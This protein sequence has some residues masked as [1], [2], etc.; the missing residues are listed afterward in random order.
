M[1]RLKKINAVLMDQGFYCKLDDLNLQLE[2]TRID[3]NFH[4]ISQHLCRNS[5]QQNV[6]TYYSIFIIATK[7]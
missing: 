5:A 1:R 2:T 7:F 6:T 3:T 4:V